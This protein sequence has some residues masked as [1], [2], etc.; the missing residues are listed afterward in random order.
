MANTTLRAIRIPD[1]LWDAALR[2]AK[3]TDSTVS[4]T[5][6]RLLTEWLAGRRK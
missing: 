4:D 6:R 1:E 2:H 3:E 5:I